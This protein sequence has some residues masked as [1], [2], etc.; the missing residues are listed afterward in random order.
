MRI[1]LL[2]FVLYPCLAYGQISKPGVE[3]MNGGSV[4]GRALSI[5][6][7]NVCILCSLSGTTMTVAFNSSCSGSVPT[8]SVTYLG[9]KVTY[10]G[11]P[12]L[13]LGK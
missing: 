13:Y 9:T 4:L 10:L 11:V 7:D 2:L 5:N 8:A 6:C 12:V 1:F 3:G